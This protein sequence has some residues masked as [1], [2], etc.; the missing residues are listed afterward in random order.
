MPELNETLTNVYPPV[1]VIEIT[2]IAIAGVEWMAL[3]CI[4]SAAFAQ[5][6][7]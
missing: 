2:E 7:G 5:T 1:L 4:Q 3:L 6:I